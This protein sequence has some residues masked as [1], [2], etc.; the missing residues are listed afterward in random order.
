MIGIR[1]DRLKIFNFETFIFQQNLIVEQILFVLILGFVMLSTFNFVC[2]L[3]ILNNGITT[4]FL[5]FIL[6]YLYK[7]FVGIIPINISNVI[8]NCFII[9]SG[10]IVSYIFA[11]LCIN[12]KLNKL[13]TILKIHRTNNKIIWT[14]LIDKECTMMVSIEMS[15]NKRYIGFLGITEEFNQKPMVSLY[16]YKIINIETNEVIEDNS[17]IANK[18]IVLDSSKALSIEIIYNKKSIII[19]DTYDFLSKVNL[20]NF[21]QNAN[22]Q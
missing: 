22:R 9:I 17:K 15:N 18:I 1:K 20:E 13:F 16:G 12:G 19:K 3:K 10:V 14:D 8:D 7:L 21:I 11:Q 4:L 2:Y 5:S 6:G